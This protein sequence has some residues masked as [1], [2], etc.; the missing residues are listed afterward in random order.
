MLFKMFALPLEWLS[1]SISIASC[2]LLPGV[3]MLVY[4]TVL[5]LSLNIVDTGEFFLMVSITGGAVCEVHLRECTLKPI[6]PICNGWVR[7]LGG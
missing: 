7:P 1:A 4:E 2:Y 3:R 5:R 6:L